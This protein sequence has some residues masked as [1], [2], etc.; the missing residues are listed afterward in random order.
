M[1]HRGKQLLSIFL[2]AVLLIGTVPATSFAALKKTEAVPALVGTIDAVDD[3][4]T[5]YR[6]IEPVKHQKTV[7]DGYIGIYTPE[8]LNRMRE[9]LTANYI[10]MNDIDMSEW[11]GWEPVGNDNFTSISIKNEE[12]FNAAKQLYHTLYDLHYNEVDDYSSVQHTYYYFS[13]F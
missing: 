9:N 3:G 13:R 2:A 1:K 4:D 8:D 7:P 11:G 12:E 5:N 6:F 10:L